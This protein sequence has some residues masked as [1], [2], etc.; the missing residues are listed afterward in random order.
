M[1]DNV[2]NDDFITEETV[3]WNLFGDVL[4]NDDKNLFRQMM[5]DLKDYRKAMGT[6]G[7][8][9]VT[10]S[11]LIALIHIQQKMIGGIDCW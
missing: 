6:K 2:T 9:Q 8:I 10:E 5:A 4:K 1:A 7:S 3:S 11:L